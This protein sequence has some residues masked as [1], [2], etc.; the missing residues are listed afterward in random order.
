MTTSDANS[1]SMM[2]QTRGT[3]CAVI[4]GGTRGIGLGAAQALGKAGHALVIN[5]RD[6]ESLAGAM[7]NLE[8]E[9][10]LVAAVPGDAADR[11]TGELLAEAA[12][13]M[14]GASVLVTCAGG[15]MPGRTWA[16][17]T[18]ED[19][20]DSHRRNLETVLVPIQA[21]AP[22][23]VSRGY[24]RIVTVSSLAGR[25]HGRFG[26][27]DYSAHK[28]AVVGM[29]R[30]IAA[31]MAPTGVTVNCVAPGL[32]DTERARHRI[33]GM[34][35]EQVEA[36]IRGT[37]IQRMGTVTEVAAAIAFLASPEAGFITGHTLDVN[38][39]VFMD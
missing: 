9:G 38:G 8:S 26:G 24:G 17:L 2:N 22:A 20:T 39:G 32:I 5:G 6:P 4:A 31:E 16:S 12:A 15:S 28:A 33:A 10:F 18:S 11:A 21:I 29:T 30:A 7:R 37:P 27:P 3:G 19:L 25:R 1:L 36:I 34:R 13:R 14:G 35:P 23:M